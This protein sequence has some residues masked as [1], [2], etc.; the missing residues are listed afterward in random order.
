[1]NPEQIPTQNPTQ[2]DP[3]LSQVNTS[4][5]TETVKTGEEESGRPYRFEMATDKADQWHWVLWGPNGRPMA[6]SGNV[7]GFANQNDC[8][9]SIRRLVAACEKSPLITIRRRD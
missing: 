5:P 6:T 3:E 1:M 2:T 4:S 7:S 8:Y 9:Q